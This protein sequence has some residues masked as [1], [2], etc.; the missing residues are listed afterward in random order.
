MNNINLLPPD[1]YNKIAAGEVVERPFGAVKELIENSIDAGATNITIEVEQGGF[2]LIRVVDNGCGIGEEDVEKAF[3][4]HATSKLST[5]EDLYEVATLGFRGEALSSIAAVSRVDMT[6]RT[7]QQDAAVSVCLEDGKV[8]SKKYVSANVGTKIEVRDLFYNTPA[9]KKFFKTPSA[10]ATAINKFVAQIAVANPSVRFKYVLDGKTVY[11]T[12]GK[13]IEDAVFCVYKKEFIDHCLPIDCNAGI[14]HIAGYISKPEFTRPNRSQQYLSINGRC[15]TD[16]GIAASIM[17]AYKAYLMTRQY[18]FYVLNVK[19]I[20]DRL[21]VNVHPKKAEVRFDEPKLVTGIIYRVINEALQE[22]ANN[23]MTNEIFAT[24]EDEE[25]DYGP[26]YQRGDSLDVLREKLKFSDKVMNSAKASRMRAAEEEAE[27]ADISMDFE[28]FAKFLD[29]NL[30]VDAA[31][32]QAGLMDDEGNC[33]AQQFTLNAHPYEEEN[34]SEPEHAAE[35]EQV[36]ESFLS[37]EYKFNF[38]DGYDYKEEDTYG[39]AEK[40]D[41]T[42]EDLAY[43]RTRVLGVAFKTYLILEFDGKILLIDQHAAHER[44]LFDKF[45][46]GYTGEVQT[47]LCPYVFKTND[48]EAQFIN[49]NIDTFEKAGV[50]IECF[51]VNTFRINAV[52][53]LLTDM[54]MGEFVKYVLSSMDELR[55]DDKKLIVDKL[56]RKACHSAIRAGYVMNEYE[57]K[58]ILRAV[59]HNQVLQCP[60]GR[61]VIVTLTKTDIEKMFKRIV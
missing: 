6:T 8:L 45:M 3:L 52:S 12:N 37:N 51:G 36:Q 18:P 10:E 13:G 60:H 35:P 29:E 53:T 5:I 1:I 7:E 15:I 11:E 28:K 4:K 9:R 40:E 14:M 20:P 43:E 22:Y 56:A 27:R 17:N 57:I 21:D 26:R 24:T 50:Y 30:S 54:E 25:E 34:A 47:L 44:I 2:S 61:P 46:D 19:M 41:L 32:R 48:D 23:K 55:V 58:S 33:V 49:E 38:G 59:I 39:N 31:R 42:E 16:Q